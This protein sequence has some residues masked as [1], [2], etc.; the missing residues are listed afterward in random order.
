MAG[1]VGGLRFAGDP[2]SLWKKG[3]RGVPWGAD[4]PDGSSSLGRSQY[5]IHGGMVFGPGFNGLEADAIAEAWMG[6]SIRRNSAAIASWTPYRPK[7]VLGPYVR[8]LYGF[9]LKPSDTIRY[10]ELE[11]RREIVF[12]IRGQIRFNLNQPTIPDLP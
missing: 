12:G 10:Q 6:W 5:G 3:K 7:M 4:K 11:E 9:V 2:P 8:G 1:A